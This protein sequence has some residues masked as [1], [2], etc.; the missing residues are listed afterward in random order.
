MLSE[1]GRDP[2]CKEKLSERGIETLLV[3]KLSEI[4]RAIIFGKQK[5]SERKDLSLFIKNLWFL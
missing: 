5:L 1:R 3:N 2:L 4:R